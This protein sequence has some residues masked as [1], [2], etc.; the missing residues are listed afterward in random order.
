MIQALPFKGYYNEMFKGSYYLTDQ[1]L[2]EQQ[3]EILP[4]NYKTYTGYTLSNSE[5]D[6]INT[7]TLRLN[8]TKDKR[9][10]EYL[11]DLRH[12]TFSVAALKMGKE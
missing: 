7:I 5:V 12:H 6:S 4:Y 10:R 1:E 9:Q 11:K 3:Q 2:E 8:Q